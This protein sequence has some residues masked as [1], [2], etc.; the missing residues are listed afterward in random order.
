[1]REE[2][3]NRL[4]SEHSKT[5]ERMRS[6]DALP[7]LTGPA[8]PGDVYIFPQSKMGVNLMVLG[9]HPDAAD[10][11]FL[12]VADWI[13]VD[14]LGGADVPVRE[15]DWHG[16]S[17]VIRC[18]SGV[19]VSRE[20]VEKRKRSK[21]RLSESYTSRCRQILSDMVSGNPL[22]RGPD[23]DDPELWDWVKRIERDIERTLAKLD[24]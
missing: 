14:L 20:T 16:E 19:W 5:V 4:L 21:V 11:L 22:P 24:G 7:D 23:E 9:Q 3:R 8:Q 2:V 15:E 17:L 6:Y 13:C 12:V 18:G 1:M 10:T